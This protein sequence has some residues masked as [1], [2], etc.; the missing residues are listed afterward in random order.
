[1]KNLDVKCLLTLIDD[2]AKL[3]A[4][5]PTLLE[6]E[7]PAYIIGDLHGNY[8]DLMKFARFFGMWYLGILLINLWFHLFQRGRSIQIPFLGGLR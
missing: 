1:M 5:E 2:A 6:I 8:E 4:T 3:L 7:S